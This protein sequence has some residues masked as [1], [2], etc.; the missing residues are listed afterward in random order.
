VKRSNHTLK[1]M[2]L[3]EKGGK[4]RTPRDKL[5]NALLTLNNFKC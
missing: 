2:F 4:I 5:N 3:K 1:E